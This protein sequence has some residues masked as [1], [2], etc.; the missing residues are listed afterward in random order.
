MTLGA[1]VLLWFVSTLLGIVAFP[2][3]FAVASRLRDRGYA[4]SKVV[5]LVLVTYVSWLLSTLKIISF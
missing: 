2:L 5:A 1:I 3:V 4:I